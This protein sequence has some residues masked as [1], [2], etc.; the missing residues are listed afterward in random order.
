M[1]PKCGTVFAVA[2]D[3][4]TP[5]EDGPGTPIEPSTE[6][7]EPPPAPSSVGKKPPE[8]GTGGAAEP[9]KMVIRRPI[10]RKVVPKKI[11]RTPVVNKGD[12]SDSDAE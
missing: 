1:C 8:G 4:Q 11:I 10:D 5:P 12:E 7:A 9:P 6:G 3:E 2:E